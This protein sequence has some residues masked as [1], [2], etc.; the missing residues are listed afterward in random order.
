MKLFVAI[1]STVIFFSGCGFQQTLRTHCHLEG[2]TCDTLFGVDQE[3][4]DNRQDAVNMNQ[5]KEIESLSTMMNELIKDLQTQE[6]QY[7]QVQTVIT[8]LNLMLEQQG[9]DI[10]II[11]QTLFS[12]NQDL[13]QLEEKIAY[14]QALINGLAIDI[15]NLQNQGDGVLITE[16]P[17]GDSPGK[18][19]EALLRLSSG[20]LLVYFENG[21][22]RF[23]TELK[24]GSY[25]TTDYSPYCHF[26]VNANNEIVSAN[27]H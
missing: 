22:N 18:F 9:A 4:I 10:E 25:R 23:L 20:K 2:Q 17:C 24:P 8:M 26:N 5:Q 19:D 12:M 3:E 14:Q 7:T 27:R 13:T 16:Y 15:A 1:A 6:N 11:N 21:E